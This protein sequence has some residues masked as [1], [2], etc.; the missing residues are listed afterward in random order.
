MP[1]EETPAAEEEPVAPIKRFAIT[2]GGALNVVMPS[3]QTQLGFRL[4]VG[5]DDWELMLGYGP[6][7]NAFFFTSDPPLMHTTAG[8][9]LYWSDSPFFQLFSGLTGGYM[10]Q[11]GQNKAGVDT[12]F[13][14]TPTVMIGGG[15]NIMPWDHFGF[16]LALDVGYPFI[17]RPELD[18]RVVF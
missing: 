2:G 10:F 1:D 14:G 13:S 3:V 17:I 6:I 12:A 15:A 16:T 5:N 7:N 9:R 11:F 8:M 18:L 4:P